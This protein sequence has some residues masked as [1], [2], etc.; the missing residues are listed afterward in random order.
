MTLIALGKLLSC[1]G[2]IERYSYDNKLDG[3]LLKPSPQEWG[4]PG[5]SSSECKRSNEKKTMNTHLHVLE[6]YTK[7]LQESGKMIF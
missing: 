2:L 6:A 3:Y 1:S 7:S 4:A 5:R